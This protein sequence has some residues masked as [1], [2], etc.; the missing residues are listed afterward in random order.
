MKELFDQ[1]SLRTSTLITKKYST[2]F[3]LGIRFLH[4]RFHDPIYAIYGYVR[5]ADEIV[6]SFHDFD[7]RKMLE[8]FRKETHAAIKNGIST[9]PVLNA[10]Q[11]VVNNYKIPIELTD[12]F[13]DSMEMDLGD[14]SYD[15][16]TYEKYILGSAE[17]V[18]LMCLKVFVDGNEKMY[19]DLKPY[20]MKLGSAFQKINF[21]RDL[22]ADY[23]ELGRTYFPGV[24]F[25]TFDETVKIQLEADI[26]EDFRQ[27]YIGIKGLPKASRFGVYVA[28]IY[29][30]R[31]LNKIQQTPA[32]DIMNARIR[33]PNR[34][35]YALFL[36]S[37]LRHSFNLL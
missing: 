14:I 21:L 17:V 9:N 12:T 10:Y 30:A 15:Q 3:S 24:D 19:D 27:G 35:K 26:A 28:Y 34:K 1:I 29:Y 7:K 5:I 36:S 37:Y 25:N 18:G 11:W 32:S 33:I 2:S 6:D 31:L 4:K 8:D 22:K 13:L 20:A 23:K 16:N